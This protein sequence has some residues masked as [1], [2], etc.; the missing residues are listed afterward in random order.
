MTIDGVYSLISSG[1]CGVVAVN[2]DC[3]VPSAS[4]L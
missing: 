4:E 2:L 1:F 3:K